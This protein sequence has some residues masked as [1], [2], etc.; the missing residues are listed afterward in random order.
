[1]LIVS[2]IQMRLPLTRQVENEQLPW[3]Y[4]FH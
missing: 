4:G 3:D 2:L 1:M